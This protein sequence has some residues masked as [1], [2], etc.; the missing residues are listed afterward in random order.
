MGNQLP[1]ERQEQVIRRLGMTGMYGALVFDSINFVSFAYVGSKLIRNPQQHLV[2][3]CFC[4]GTAA[5]AYTV[6]DTLRVAK[7]DQFYT[8]T[9]TT[10]ND[11]L[12]CMGHW[13]FVFQFYVSAADTKIILW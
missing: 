6:A 7:D 3:L 12:F 4:F 10:V 5:L 1:L 8:H 9:L 2:I 11:I 13:K